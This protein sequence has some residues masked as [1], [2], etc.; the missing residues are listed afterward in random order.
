ML[1]TNYRDF[2]L[3][4]ED[5]QG[6]PTPLETFRLADSADDFERRL[7]KPRAFAR[8]VGAGL[9]EYL[10]RDALAQGRARRAARP[11]RGCSHLMPVTVLARVEAVQVTRRP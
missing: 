3:L 2:V 10:C 5:A 9:A 7:Q 4:G 1:V 6:Q 11:W 8:A